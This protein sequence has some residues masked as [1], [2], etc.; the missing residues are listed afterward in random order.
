MER[1]SIFVDGA[2]C[3]YAQRDVLK[4]QIDWVRLLGH[5]RE[6]FDVVAASYYRALPSP[7]SPGDIAFGSALRANGFA[8]REKTLKTIF[9]KGTSETR[10]KGN[11]DIELV[12][13]ALMTASRYDTCLLVSGDG[14]FAPLIQALRTSS[15]VVKVLSTRGLVANELLDQVGLDF[16]DFEDLRQS[17]ERPPASKGDGIVRTSPRSLGASNPST[18]SDGSALTDNTPVVGYEYLATV[19]SVQKG[20][21]NVTGPSGLQAFLPVSRLGIVGY[22]EDTSKFLEIGDTFTVVV[23]DISTSEETP[24]ITV[25]LQDYEA[26]KRLQQKFNRQR[27]PFDAIPDSGEYDLTVSSVKPYGAFLQNPWGAK[28]LLHVSN[29]GIE[30]FCPDCTLVIRKGE[31]VR[32]LVT[33]KIT[34]RDGVILN[35]RL[36]DPDYLQGILERIDSLPEQGGARFP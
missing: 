2:N 33:E 1:M 13:D 5:Y 28:I 36:V 3:F 18:L 30:T 21:A 25:E 4:W 6:S 34:T 26:Q 7:P 24:A 17:L 23:A 8:L 16:D 29:L 10:Q 20:G 32:V 19:E 31:I 14:D 35:V 12:I 11:L 27:T 15:K 22:I 9:N